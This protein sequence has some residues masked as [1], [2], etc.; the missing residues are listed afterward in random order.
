MLI[1]P[2]LA[3]K[4]G[5]WLRRGRTRRPSYTLDTDSIEPYQEELRAAIPPPV[6]CALDEATATVAQ[7]T[8]ADRV[9]LAEVTMPGHH[10][11]GPCAFDWNATTLPKIRPFPAPFIAVGRELRQG[12]RLDMLRFVLAHEARHRAPGLQVPQFLLPVAG[13][14]GF[15]L[16]GLL[17]PTLA[18]AVIAAIA[19]RVAVTLGHWLVELTCDHAA[20]RAHGDGGRFFATCTPRRFRSCARAWPWWQ[21][22]L[23]VATRLQPS[24]PPMWL[25][26][27]YCRR[28]HRA[29]LDVDPSRPLTVGLLL[30]LATYVPSM[31]STVAG[32]MDQASREGAH[33]GMPVTYHMAVTVVTC[34]LAWWCASGARLRY[35]VIVALAVVSVLFAVERV[36]EPWNSI[37]DPLVIAALAG[38]LAVRHLGPAARP[39]PVRRSDLL[40]LAVPL[41]AM[42]FASDI[43]GRMLEW[44]PPPGSE[45]TQLETLGISG[46]AELLAKIVWTSVL[47]EA[48]STLLIIGLLRRRM[49]VWA[50]FTVTAVLRIGVHLYAAG[51]ALGPVAMSVTMTA[52]FLYCRRLWPLVIA[53]AIYNLVV[54]YLP[55][56]LTAIVMGTVAVALIVWATRRLT[57]HGPRATGTVT[58]PADAVTAPAAPGR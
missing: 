22:V 23:A 49:P 27:W 21:R 31:I 37:A 16:A 58:A 50:I 46:D 19:L 13:T 48:T 8:R 47:E 51:G 32:W 3:V 29:T 7:H 44:L 42:S 41:P 52:L 18:S 38:W 54:S 53:H 24:H 28:V 6:A 12:S 56:P 11:D 5:E 10:H 45:K 40:L 39:F 35:R 36:P 9:L 15:F 17:A 34:A 43:W 1:V 33:D 55:L 57:G 30:F 20:A 4:A 25:R 2:T 26:A 14:A